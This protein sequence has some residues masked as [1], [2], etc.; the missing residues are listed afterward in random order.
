[1]R[2]WLILMWTV[3][4]AAGTC[5]GV[6]LGSANHD[7]ARWTDPDAFDI[8]REPHNHLAFADGE[9]FCLG[10]HLA[11]AS[12][13]ALVHELAGRVESLEFSGPVLQ[14]ESSFVVGLKSLPVRYRIRPARESG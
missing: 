2:R 9:H 11:R 12:T 5:S 4:V 3:L 6:A 8:E 1:M 7:D 13:H 14:T 10:A